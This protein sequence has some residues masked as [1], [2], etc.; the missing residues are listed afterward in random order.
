ME[1]TLTLSLDP[2][3]AP[4]EAAKVLEQIRGMAGVSRADLLAPEA[5]N[6]IARSMA[7]VKLASESDAEAAAKKVAAVPGV[8]SCDVAPA[9]RLV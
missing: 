7:Y 9:R 4:G 3:L 2:E 8:V 5:K 1:K 6:R